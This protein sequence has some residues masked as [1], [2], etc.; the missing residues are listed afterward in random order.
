MNTNL[1]INIAKD[2]YGNDLVIDLSVTKYL[3][4]AGNAG[5]GKSTLLHNILSKLLSTNSPSDLKLILIDPKQVELN[6]YK[7]VPHLLT[8]VITETKKAILA[9]KWS[10]KEIDR[11]HDLLK[12]ENCKDITNYQG[13]EYMPRIV[14]VIDEFSDLMLAYPKETEPLVQKIAQ[15][16]HVVGIHIVLATSQSGPKVLTK[17]IRDAISAR[18]ALQTSTA[19]D[20]KA[21]IGTDGACLLR[22][23]GDILY[24]DGMKYIIHGQ[25]DF[26][27]YED[28]KTLCESIKESYKE[29]NFVEMPVTEPQPGRNSIFDGVEEFSDETGDEL[30]DEARELVIAARKASTPY[31]QRRL[32]VGYA[33]AAGLIDML[34]ERGVIASGSGAA[35]RKVL[36]N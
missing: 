26:V 2:E 17:S 8:P 22:R 15:M 19:Q 30:Y 3:L 18:I 34:E 21:I 5:S 29:S 32:K 25:A 36:P 14:I 12:D 11:R 27:S 1:N 35:P 28:V 33:R 23:D 7:D 20:S 16:G 9:M 31:L 13:Q 24:R 6:A 4:I 10:I